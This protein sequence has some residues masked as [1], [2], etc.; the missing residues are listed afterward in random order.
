MLTE[1]CSSLNNQ[2]IAH[3]CHTHLHR[4]VIGEVVRQC[5]GKFQTD[6]K[7][8]DQRLLDANNE[9]A[10]AQLVLSMVDAMPLLFD[11]STVNEDLTVAEDA[12]DDLFEQMAESMPDN[13]R[14]YIVHR[15]VSK[16]IADIMFGLGPLQD[17]LEMGNVSEIMVVGKDRI[18]VEKNDLLVG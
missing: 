11:Q 7:I 9:Q 10:I 18:Y 5:Q 14:L 3:A 8:T 2:L 4:L 12:F 17:L 13:L 1:Q 16:D 6:Y 15:T